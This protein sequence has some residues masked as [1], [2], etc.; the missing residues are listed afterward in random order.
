MT[1]YIRETKA[2]ASFK[3][4]TAWDG[5]VHVSP[6]LYLFILQPNSRFGTDY[7]VF[8]VYTKNIGSFWH[9]YSRTSWALLYSFGKSEKT[10]RCLTSPQFETWNSKEYRTENAWS[11]LIPSH[12]SAFKG[13]VQRDGSGWN[14]SQIIGLPQTKRRPPLSAGSVHPQGRESHSKLKRQLVQELAIL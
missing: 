2:G 11:A 4:Y 14:Y 8:S 7:P 5:H 13:S 1:F 10:R 12:F 9:L 6:I 3:I